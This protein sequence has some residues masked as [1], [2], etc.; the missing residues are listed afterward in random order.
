MSYGIR[1]S[2][3]NKGQCNVFDSLHPILPSKAVEHIA[4]LLKCKLPSFELR[5]LHGANQPNINECG[6][7]PLLLQNRYAGEKTLPL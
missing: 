6:F 5:Y 7:M 4:A 3:D 2:V 1:H